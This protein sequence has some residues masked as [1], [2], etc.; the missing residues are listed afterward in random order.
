[1]QNA[2]SPKK[3]PFIIR[4]LFYILLAILCFF[5]GFGAYYFGKLVVFIQNIA[6]QKAVVSSPATHQP[7]QMNILLLGSDND[8]KFTG[9][10]LT[11]TMMIIHLDYAKKE[12]DMFSIQIGRAHV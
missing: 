6:N 8:Q 2:S 12:I 11:Q 7:G 5:L 10:P 4:L 3:K 1:M 9:N